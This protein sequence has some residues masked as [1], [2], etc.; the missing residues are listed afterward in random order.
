[1]HIAALFVFP[2][3]G[4]FICICTH[5][6]ISFLFGLEWEDVGHI[7]LTSNTRRAR[8]GKRDEW[9]SSHS[10]RRKW[11]KNRAVA[12]DLLRPMTDGGRCPRADERFHHLLTALAIC[13]TPRCYALTL[14]RRHC[15]RASSSWRASSRGAGGGA[16]RV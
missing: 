2:S 15:P 14:W 13:R 16:G 12:E 7:L 9:M 6:C 5:T 1:V 10:E 3:L 4:G 8:A 11:V